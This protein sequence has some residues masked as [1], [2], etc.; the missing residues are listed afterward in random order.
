MRKEKKRRLPRNS[1]SSSSTSKVRSKSRDC[2]QLSF[3]LGNSAKTGGAPMH[4]KRQVE[5]GARAFDWAGNVGLSGKADTSGEV[6]L[7]CAALEG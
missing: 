3:V 7:A 2:C 4:P 5:P 6:P 1:H